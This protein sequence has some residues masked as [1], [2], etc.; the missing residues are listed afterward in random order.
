VIV[1]PGAGG[2]VLAGPALGVLGVLLQQPLVGVALDVG[3][4]GCPPLAVDQVGDEALQ[5]GRILDL[6]LGLAE[7]DPE[8]SRLAPQR[9][10]RVPV[11]ALQGIAVQPDQRG[12][13]E[14]GRDGRGLVIGRLGPLVGHLEEQQVGELLDVVPVGEAVVAEDIAIVPEFG[15]HLL[16]V[17]AGHLRFLW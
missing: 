1:S 4:E 13:V 15:D 12:P 7:D 9:L 8:H 11:L 16:G 6:V 10:Q 2:E 17:R 3:V 5:L 14:P